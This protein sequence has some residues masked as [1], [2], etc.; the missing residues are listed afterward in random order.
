MGKLKQYVDK[1]KL[2]KKAQKELNAQQRG[3]WQGVKPYTRIEAT[4]TSYKRQ[5]KHKGKMDDFDR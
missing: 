5:P 1:S 4:K 2:S 3:S